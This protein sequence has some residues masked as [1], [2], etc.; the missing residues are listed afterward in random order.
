[1]T[2]RRGYIPALL[3][4]ALTVVVWADPI[5]T[6][7]NFTGRDLLPYN[8]PAE[9]VIHDA[10][11]SGSLPIWNPYISGGRPLLANPNSGAL[12]PVRMVL[13]TLPFETAMRVYPVL[14]WLA[15]GLGMLWLARSLGLSRAGAFLGAVTYA[16]SGAAVSEV[17]YPHILPGLAIFPWIL[18]AVH[19]RSALG[20]WAIPL[21]GALFGLDFI[22]GDVFTGGLAIAAALSWIFL[23]S[24]RPDWAS[25]RSGVISLA[26]AIG[27]GALLAAPQIVAT[28]LWIPETNR[29]VLGMKLGEANQFS[30]SP[31]R[32]IELLVPYP[33]GPAFDLRV[34]L[35][36]GQR[37][38]NGK[39][40]GLFSTLYCGT[41][42]PLAAWRLRK[43]RSRGARFAVLF[44]SCAGA[45]AVLPSLIPRAWEA[46]RSPV[47]LRNPEK[48]VVS[49]ALCLALLAA[50]GFDDFRARPLN[51]RRALVVGGAFAIAAALGAIFS[52]PLGAWLSERLSTL[53][54]RAPVAAQ[55]VPGAL[56]EAGLL[57]MATV[58]ALDGARSSRRGIVLASVGLL[59]L[60]P[61]SATRRIGETWHPAAVFA[62]TEFA[63]YVR[64]RDPR[65]ERRV[66]G[67]TI[68]HELDVAKRPTYDADIVDRPRRDWVAHTQALWK[69][70]TVL[71]G[72]FDAG[73]F[74]RIE[75]LRRISGFASGYPESVPF[76]ANLGLR[77]GIRYAADT[78]VSAYRPFTF[79]GAQAWDRIDGA[80]A[81]V[82]L[83][84][85][86][87]EQ[88]GALSALALLPKMATGDLLLETDRQAAGSARPGS[89]R[90]LH[91]SP[92]HMVWECR[93]SDPTWLFVLRGFWRHRRVEVDGAEVEVFPAY[94]AFSAVPIPAGTHRVEW[95]ELAPGMP[96]SL[97]APVI[98]VL[99]MLWLVAVRKEGVTGKDDSGSAPGKETE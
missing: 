16:F 74:A 29:A 73:D 25:R 19:R 59:A 68:Y 70:G 50:R 43:S 46:W 53:P 62:P 67:E 84:T 14:H 47:P 24:D 85:R 56:A 23:E 27:L 20:R 12:Y 31:L 30:V 48:L 98:A 66:L 91:S 89:I 88:P 18:W 97:A 10:Y 44:G 7:R 81:D 58:V 33:F 64:A 11:S 5:F 76:Y 9:K 2:G 34:S 72:D 26:A 42:A 95:R 86:W 4:V 60:V 71:N 35:L 21:L 90:V 8:L 13:A 41:L 49:I 99:A 87:T 45:L 83:A 51:G 65:H 79:R 61:I 52:A 37:A 63:R 92:A 96:A 17:F 78:P 1:M 39:S 69:I 54:G 36:W 75:S 40:I 80:L 82:R 94:L 38:F 57:W 15:A 6:G 93:S 77:W 28:A 22:A 32:L 3:F 55:M